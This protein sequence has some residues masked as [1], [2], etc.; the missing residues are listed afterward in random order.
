MSKLL[1]GGRVMCYNGGARDQQGDGVPGEV[2]RNLQAVR[3]RIARAAARA[4]RPASEIT[5]VAV[6]K[7]VPV[8]RIE[9]AVRAGAEHIGENYVQEARE[10]HAR[11][12]AP[13]T[14]HLIGHLQ[15]NKAGQAAQIFDVIHTVDS[16]RL[17]Q[18]LSRR[19]VEAGRQLEVLVEVNIAAEPSKFGVA[20]EEALPLVEALAGLPALRPAGLM[21]MAPLSSQPEEARPHFRRL[22]AL[23]EKL[24]AAYRRHLSMGMSSDFEVAIEE[25]AT[26]VRVGTAIFG[27]RPRPHG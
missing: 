21:G 3:E 26:I 14:W 22:R 18:H 23:W 19:A 10:K 6:T 11:I 16:L 1:A 8:E 9:E 5:L 17:A 25:G 15:S 24:P 7:T 20:P 4:G 12:R 13:L 27:P 2:A